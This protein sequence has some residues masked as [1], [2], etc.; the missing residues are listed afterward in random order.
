M[1]EEILVE[2]KVSVDG[3]KA[4][5]KTV[6]NEFK[7][8]EETAIKGVTATDE[9]IKDTTK[10]TAS[11]TTQLKELK[12]QISLATDPKDVERLAKAAASV[13]KEINGINK[14]VD[15]F[16][17][18]K[19]QNVST[20]FGDIG[21]KIKSLDFAGAAKESKKLLSAV[22][23]ISFKDVIGSIK[24]V[25]TTLV[26]VG[27]AVL[28][29]PLFILAGVLVGISKAAYD[30][31]QSMKMVGVQTQTVT[32]AINEQTK[33]IAG[34]SDR[35]A[36]VYIN[37]NEGLG[38]YTQAQAEVKRSEIKNNQELVVNKQK[39][40]EDLV[41]LATELGVN[42]SKLQNGFFDETYKGDFEDLQNKKRFNIEKQKLDR[43]Y[44]QQNMAAV[45]TQ[46]LEKLG[47]EIQGNL[48]S[49]KK[50]QDFLN[51]NREKQKADRQKESEDAIAE[52]ERL[53][54]LLR[55]LK[56]RGMESEYEKK[57]A[58]IIAQYADEQKKEAGHIDIL[59]Q[60]DK[61]REKELRDLYIAREKE[62]EKIRKDGADKSVEI[63]KKSSDEMKAE[64]TKLADHVI[65]N[66]DKIIKKVELTEKQRQELNKATLDFIVSSIN[67]LQ[68]ISN[69]LNQRAIDDNKTKADAEI[70]QQDKLYSQGLISKEQYEENINI[71][72]KKAAE[73]EKELKEQQFEANKN[74]AVIGALIATAQGVAGALAQTAELGY[75]AFALAALIAASGALQVAAIESQP[76]PKFEKGG[77]LKG[78]RHREGGVLVEAERD[79]WIINRNDAMKN[80]KLL[81]AINSGK[82]EQFIFDHYIAP[83]LKAQQKKN[84]EGKEQSFAKNLANSMSLNFKDGNLLDSLKQSRK[85]DKEI[86]LYMVKELKGSGYNPRKW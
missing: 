18:S 2:Y 77:K 50:S 34:Y 23:A 17:K 63:F 29:N 15:A 75:A 85:N 55:D 71:I 22:N 76:T 47:I 42:L 53:A 16:T 62:Y 13:Q 5:L 11:L 33:A 51:A 1:A 27:K 65:Q 82:G 49:I 9:K 44:H 4:E 30:V 86:A 21:Y 39:Y 81:G 57:K 70:A 28:S 7:K 14:Q 32:D 56:I 69:N 43:L 72:N 24:D 79:E 58:T 78:K 3:L 59:M 67:S 54:K 37:L 84:A 41:K 64:D 60:L 74:A 45:K 80:D 35:V 26:T 61:N 19:Y 48:D 31:T 38:K 8:T 36:Q 73:K 46:L 10:S 68:E 20:A 66:Q 12:K 83:A 6:Q 52:A 25:G 40:S